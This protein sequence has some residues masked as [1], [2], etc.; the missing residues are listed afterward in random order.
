MERQRDA[1]CYQLLSSLI[2]QNPERLQ[3]NHHR[4]YFNNLFVN[5]ECLNC[6]KC[7]SLAFFLQNPNQM[8]ARGEYHMLTLFMKG[9]PEILSKGP[10]CLLSSQQILLNTLSTPSTEIVEV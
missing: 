7:F 5:L 8:G 9:N 2:F 4:I 10:E 3:F 6:F 1:R